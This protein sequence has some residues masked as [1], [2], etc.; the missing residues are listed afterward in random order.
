MSTS[1]NRWIRIN[2]MERE[3]SRL[4]LELIS[5]HGEAQSLMERINNAKK[6]LIHLT[7]RG[8]VEDAEWFI[9]GIE[10]ALADLEG[11]DL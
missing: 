6:Q 2:A 5:A 1:E 7:D 3:L 11:G 9:D 10:H 4:R 8:A